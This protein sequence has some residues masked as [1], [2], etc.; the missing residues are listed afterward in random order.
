MQVWRADAGVI[1]HL[2]DMLYAGTHSAARFFILLC[3][4]TTYKSDIVQL[5]AEVLH[6]E[7]TEQLAQREKLRAH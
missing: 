4:E 1:I 3:C 6:L 5:Y 7:C 2:H